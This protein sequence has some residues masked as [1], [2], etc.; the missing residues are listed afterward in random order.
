ML[1]SLAEGEPASIAADYQGAFGR[2]KN[3]ANTMAERI[4][5]DDRRNQIVGP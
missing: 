5:L 4:G 3:D 1:S 2:L